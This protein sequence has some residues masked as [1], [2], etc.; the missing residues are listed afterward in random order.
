M[1]DKIVV[2]VV[3]TIAFIMFALMITVVFAQVILR[4]FTTASLAWSDEIA[5]FLMIWISFLG[6]TIIHYSDAGHP[7]M[8]FLADR[9]PLRPRT[10]IN[11]ILNVALVIGFAALAIAGAKFTI[12]NHSFTSTVLGWPNSYKYVVFPI[13]MV[14]M[15]IKSLRRLIADVE[16]LAGKGE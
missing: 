6:V 11:A 9:L 14:L 12:T 3:R 13:C 1:F 10:I 2:R 5:R 15:G 4:Y 16:E 7:G 8:D